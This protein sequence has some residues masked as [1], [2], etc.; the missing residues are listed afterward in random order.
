MKTDKDLIEELRKVA[1]GKWGRA[2]RWCEQHGVHQPVV[3][4]LLNGQMRT[5][6]TQVAK[7]LGY[8]MVRTFVRLPDVQE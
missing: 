1:S 7:A 3:S 8:K 5:V 6:P 2:G 4:Q